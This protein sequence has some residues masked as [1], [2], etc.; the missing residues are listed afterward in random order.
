MSSSGHEDQTGANAL[1]QFPQIKIIDLNIQKELTR[2][3]WVEPGV[4]RTIGGIET[5]G[6]FFVLEPKFHEFSFAIDPASEVGIAECAEPLTDPSHLLAC[7]RLFHNQ[8]AYFLTFL[9]GQ[10]ATPHA[11]VIKPYLRLQ[12]SGFEWRLFVL[13][14]TGARLFELACDVLSRVGRDSWQPVLQFIAWWAALRSQQDSIDL[15]EAF[16]HSCVWDVPVDVVNF[17]L[18]GCGQLGHRISVEMIFSLVW[19]LGRDFSRT[20]RDA[21]VQ[22]RVI[23]RLKAMYP[24]GLELKV[25]HQNRD[26]CFY[27][28]VC[29]ELNDTRIVQCRVPFKAD[30]PEVDGLRDLVARVERIASGIVSGPRIDAV[31]LKRIKIETS[32]V[33]ADLAEHLPALLVQA[34]PVAKTN[35][36][37]SPGDRAALAEL[38]QRSTWTREDFLAVARKHHTMPFALQEKLNSWC[39]VNF[40]E[41]LL[42]GD[43]P[44]KVDQTVINKLKTYADY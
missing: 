4:R 44:I 18:V 10:L 38:I 20:C 6:G 33:Q 29:P 16:C 25:S 19:V 8:R 21:Q 12:L 31:K 32:R 34:P 26:T 41:P 3:L 40:G 27:R 7:W 28:P 9:S 1:I 2:L 37:L 30:V 42:T 35:S 36:D 11:D 24:A 22:L 14:D 15:W 5:N 17:G 43:G 23:D 13:H 39:V